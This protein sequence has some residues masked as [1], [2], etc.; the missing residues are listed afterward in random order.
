[1]WGPDLG[2]T[3]QG[4]AGAELGVST[5]RRGRGGPPVPWAGTR[6][7]PST[8]WRPSTARYC[9]VLYCTVLYCTVYYTVY[10]TVLCTAGGGRQQ[11]VQAEREQEQ[12][13]QQVQRQLRA[14]GAGGRHAQVGTLRSALSNAHDISITYLQPQLRAARD[15]P[16]PEPGAQQGGGGAGGRGGARLQPVHVPRPQPEQPRRQLQVVTCHNSAA[17][18]TLSNTLQRGQLPGLRGQT[19]LRPRIQQRR[20]SRRAQHQVALE[21]L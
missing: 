15:E 2:C 11:A 17:A 7:T 14:P 6:A 1:M 8:P 3:R 13:L 18:V 20:G 9:T 16:G 5:A 19:I 4:V 10:R 21:Y 12:Q